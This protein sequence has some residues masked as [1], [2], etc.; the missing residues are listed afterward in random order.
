MTLFDEDEDCYRRPA[1]ADDTEAS[2]ADEVNDI[3]HKS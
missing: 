1:K 2:K 3:M